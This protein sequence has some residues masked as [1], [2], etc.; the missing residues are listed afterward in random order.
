MTGAAAARPDGAP[1]PD[2][3]RAGRGRLVVAAGFASSVAF[4]TLA[5]ARL[6]LADVRAALAGA[7]LFPWLPLAVA[8]YVAGH[9]ARGVR[10]RLLVQDEAAIATSTA[11]HVVVL[12]YAVNNLLPARLGELARA[13]MLAQR[14]GLPFVQTLTVTFLERLLDGLVLLGLLVVAS[15]ALP[16]LD[17]VRTT[18]ELGTLVFGVA[19]GGALL[20]LLAPTALLVAASRIAQRV[21]PRLHGPVVGLVSSATRGLSALRRGGAAAKV[22]ALSVVVWVLEAGLFLALLPAFGLPA[23]PATAL[24]ALGITNLGI[25]VPSSPGFVGAFHYFCMRSLSA[26]G[27][28]EPVALSYAVLVHLGFYVPVTLWGLFVLGS[29][30]ASLGDT[31][32]EARRAAPVARLEDLGGGAPPPARA[33]D[34]SAFLVALVDALLPLEE[35]PLAA[36]D[37]AGVAERSA[38]FV[39]VSV[40]SLPSRLLLLHRAGML[41]FAALTWL[42]FARPLARVPRPAR[43]AWVARF[44]RGPLALGR[45][46]F[47]PARSLSLVACYDDPAVQRAL[48][49]AAPGAGS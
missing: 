20:A 41:A 13:G 5:V 21:A 2:P 6:D 26:L 44:A 1:E 45:Q 18:L 46:L 32:R 17:W 49:L 48:A 39:A 8:S 22:L 23:R 29:H 28:P 38:R 37:R 9:V 34:P 31:L 43:R 47:R 14:T 11:T 42:R 12:G 35:L 10:C 40:A 16:P 27:V 30:G 24:L 36:G 4:T 25:L 15:A 19:S 33:P 3:A 7:R